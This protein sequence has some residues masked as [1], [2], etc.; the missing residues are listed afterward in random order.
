MIGKLRRKLR[1]QINGTIQ[2]EQ[3]RKWWNKSSFDDGYYNIVYFTFGTTP[4]SQN[5]FVNANK[6][7][8]NDF[9]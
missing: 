7:K 5:G 8:G 4:P 9:I 1:C 2:W 3:K 6:K